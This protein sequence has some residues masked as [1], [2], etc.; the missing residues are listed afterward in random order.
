MSHLT[1][2]TSLLIVSGI[3]V[4]VAH[5]LMVHLKTSGSWESMN[6]SCRE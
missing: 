4:L 5:K 6:N 1:S 3:S 2:G